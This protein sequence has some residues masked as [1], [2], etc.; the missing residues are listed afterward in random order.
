M[1]TIRSSQVFD[2]HAEAYDR[3]FDVHADIY[4][5]EIN[6]VRHFMP[7]T[8]RGLEVGVG[9]GRFA[10]PFG[11]TLGVEPSLHMARIAQTRGIAVCQA[12]GEQLPFVAAQFDFVL[13][14]TVICFVADVSTLLH[15]MYRVLKHSGQL[16]VGFIDRQSFLGRLYESRRN[17]DKFY[18][19]AKF[20]SVTE[21]V[22]CAQQVGFGHLQFCQTIF[23][24]PSNVSSTQPTCGG[25]GQGA[26][27]VMSAEKLTSTGENERDSHIR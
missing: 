22:A 10:A 18:R 25:H 3:W 2:E 15:E 27:V 5:A 17:T 7:P 19:G 11:I 20:Y 8:G 23:G 21:V 14:V 9:T 24:L 12:L 1:T 6:A 16:I 26:F 13:L 4:Q